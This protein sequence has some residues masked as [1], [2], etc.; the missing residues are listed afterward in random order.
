MKDKYKTKKQFLMELNEL[1]HQIERLERLEKKVKRVDK[2]RLASEQKYRF[3]IENIN[4]ILISTDK[5]GKI[6][7][8][9]PQVKRLGYSPDEVVSKN[10]IDFILPEDRERVLGDFQHTM[11]SGEEFPTE[12][13]MKD[14]K[15]RTFWFEDIGKVQRDE[16]GKIVGLT[17]ILRDINERKLM[18]IE[19][20]H[21]QEQ[22][23]GLAGHLQFLREKDKRDLA[24]E[25]HD[26]MGQKLTALKMEV[27]NLHKKLP[28][29]RTTLLEITKLLSDDLDSLIEKV[30]MISSDLKP[31]LLD[32]F[33][34]AGAF[35]TH[36]NE[37]QSRTGIRCE[38]SLGIDKNINLDRG[39]SLAIFRILQES[40][41]NVAR[42]SGAS[43]VNIALEEKAGE[44]MLRI[45][46]NGKG[47]TEKQISDPGSF[48][49][50]GMKERTYPW[51]GE[52]K[53]KSIQG[54]GT[55]I[56]IKFPLKNKRSQ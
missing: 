8:V 54:K 19:L 32:E 18:E 15:G 34:L 13:R 5:E 50:I 4:D 29:D 47:M 1:R 45:K 24:R 52:L 16:S 2:A 55:T 7:Y 12:F 46:D 30:K 28:R 40:L 27:R 56:S 6:T 11:L 9:S 25:L 17:G 36:I 38:L 10:S 53:I 3:L 48:G 35:E 26:E 43:R 37:F 33:G 41:T 31:G 14:K 39:L 51:K 49:L 22:L 44:L 23:R 21:T 42:H 20:K